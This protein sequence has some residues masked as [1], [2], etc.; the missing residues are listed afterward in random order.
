MAHTVL[1]AWIWVHTS[2]L[3][4]IHTGLVLPDL[5]FHFVFGPTVVC[6]KGS[7]GAAAPWGIHSE[8]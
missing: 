4:I 3:P 8:E 5:R 2:S 1:P 7:A 6:A